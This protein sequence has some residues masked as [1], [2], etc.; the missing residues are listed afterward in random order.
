MTYSS[1]DIIIK[2]H[3]IV[4]I[5]RI[6]RFI[7]GDTNQIIWTFVLFKNGYLVCCRKDL[8]FLIFI[9]SVKHATIRSILATIS[10][11][12]DRW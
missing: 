2:H 11:L 6:S 1:T 4:G 12:I 9:P 5:V 10:A 7:L 3:A 8:Q